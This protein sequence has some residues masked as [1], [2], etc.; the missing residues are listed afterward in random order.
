MIEELLDKLLLFWDR[1]SIFSHDPKDIEMIERMYAYD[2][3]NN[4]SN[5]AAINNRGFSNAEEQAVKRTNQ[6]DRKYIDYAEKAMP[7]LKNLH[8]EITPLNQQQILSQAEEDYAGFM[9]ASHK[10]E[11]ELARLQLLKPDRFPKSVRMMKRAMM[12]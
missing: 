4:Y 9:L 7:S 10:A 12:K 1:P 11:I 2:K 6:F 3:Y 8:V 5:I